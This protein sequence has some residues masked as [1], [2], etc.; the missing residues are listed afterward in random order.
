M[1]KEGTFCFLVLYLFIFST[2]CA[3]T[4]GGPSW[5]PDGATAPVRYEANFTESST[6]LSELNIR[7]IDGEWLVV[8]G[9]LTLLSPRGQFIVPAEYEMTFPITAEYDVY[10]MNLVT[11]FTVFYHEG[12]FWTE[13]AFWECDMSNDGLN[14]VRIEYRT[15][16]FDD[17]VK[18]CHSQSYDFDD[19]GG[20]YAIVTMTDDVGLTG[21]PAHGFTGSPLSIIEIDG[22]EVAS[23]E[24]PLSES[25][26]SSAAVSGVESWS[27]GLKINY[28]S[29][30]ESVES[31]EVEVGFSDALVMVMEMLFFIP[32]AVFMP[33]WLNFIAVKVPLMVAVH[34]GYCLVRGV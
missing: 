31:E 25:V 23:G 16:P 1:G 20:H 2:V 8:D 9:N 5:N 10:D 24:I 13:E 12:W 26:F 19:A 4:F 15:W 21:G 18:Y 33:F 32:P 34:H 7:V 30:V 14:L 3:M 28:L 17:V 27:E 22:V 29:E 6:N 11:R